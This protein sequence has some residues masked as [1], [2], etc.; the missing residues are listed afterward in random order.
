M[1]KAYIQ[2]FAETVP[3]TDTSIQHGKVLRSDALKI[4]TP[5]GACVLG[6]IRES[7]PL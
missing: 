7:H 6:C 1:M 4:V 3:S 2:Q 5:R